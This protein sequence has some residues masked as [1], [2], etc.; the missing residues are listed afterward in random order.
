MFSQVSSCRCGPL[1]GFGKREVVGLA[2]Y[3]HQGF[4]MGMSVDF[5]GG[6]GGEWCRFG[7]QP[8]AGMGG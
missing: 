3:V 7:C 1:F 6:I 8:A 5:C 2:R 4:E